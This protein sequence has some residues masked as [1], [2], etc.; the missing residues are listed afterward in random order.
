MIRN[1]KRAR[2]WLAVVA[3]LF[4]L[5]TSMPASV[6]PGR[7]SGAVQSERPAAAKRGSNEIRKVTKTDEEWRAQ[8]TPDQYE[9]T[10]KRG[11]ERPFSGAYHNSKDEGL[12]HCICC[13]LELFDSRKKFDSGTGW[14]SYWAPIKKNHIIEVRD[15][16]HGMIR[17][18]VVCARC[19]AHLGHVF[20]DGPPPTYLRYCINSVAL[21]FV[22]KEKQGS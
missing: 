17:T 13:D 12:Y 7:L 14:P 3:I 9:V 6:V 11:T 5:A 8:L 1:H 20:N 22:K 15:T 19:D 21:R 2:A 16:S 18:E 4:G 10:R